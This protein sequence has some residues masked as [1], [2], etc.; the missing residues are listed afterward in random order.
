MRV[1]YTSTSSVHQKVLVFQDLEKSFA[2][3]Y[4]ILQIGAGVSL[5]PFLSIIV[6]TRL[7]S[8]DCTRGYVVRW[9]QYKRCRSFAVVYLEPFFSPLAS[10]QIA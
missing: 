9:Y 10:F 2:Y 1:Q 6:K 8:A 3:T 7:T 4:L 5:C